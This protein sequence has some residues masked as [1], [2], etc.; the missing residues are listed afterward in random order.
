[1]TAHLLKTVLY[2]V[3]VVIVYVYF[4]LAFSSHH[5]ASSETDKLLVTQV[6]Q[7]DSNHNAHCVLMLIV[8]LSRRLVL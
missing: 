4:V 1:M 5:I 7:T 3:E 8:S 2:A 6:D